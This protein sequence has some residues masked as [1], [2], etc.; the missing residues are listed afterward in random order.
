MNTYQVPTVCQ[1]LFQFCFS[2]HYSPFDPVRQVLLFH[3]T[4]QMKKWRLRDVNSWV[5]APAT[6]QLAELGF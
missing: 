3:S 2:S 1:D 5:Q 4:L 6:A